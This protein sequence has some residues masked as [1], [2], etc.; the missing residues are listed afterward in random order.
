MK[1]SITYGTGEHDLLTQ[2]L[3]ITITTVTVLLFVFVIWIL[4]RLTKKNR[5]K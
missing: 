3:P 1:K 4:I 2:Y 5:T